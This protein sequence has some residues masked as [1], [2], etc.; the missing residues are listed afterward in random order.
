MLLYFSSM[1]INQ[2]YGSIVNRQPV[3]NLPDDLRVLH[4]QC[5][6]RSTGYSGLSA[7]R[8]LLDT[9]GEILQV[10]MEGCTPAFIYAGKFLQ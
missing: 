7:N 3:I 2:N 5:Q 4:G 1:E 9:A 6:E 8:I 10:I